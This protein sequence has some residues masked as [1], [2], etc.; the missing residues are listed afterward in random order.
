[1]K[2]PVQLVKLPGDLTGKREAY[3][4]IYGFV[5]ILALHTFKA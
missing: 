3:L 1:M 4:T 2:M 5:L